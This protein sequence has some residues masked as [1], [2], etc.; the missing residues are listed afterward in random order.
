MHEMNARF[1]RQVSEEYKPYFH[2]RDLDV[3]EVGSCNVNGAVLDN[4][5]MPHIRTYIG[6]DWREG[7]GVTHIGLAHEMNFDKQFDVVIS[8]SM[9]EHDP[10]WRDSL[11]VMAHHLKETGLF[12][13]SWGA[14]LNL[15]HGEELAPDEEY[16]GLKVEPVL[17]HLRS[18][19]LYVHFFVYEGNHYQEGLN[20]PPECGMGEVGLVAFRTRKK[21]PKLDTLLPED[22]C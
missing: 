12:A 4:L 1:W 16:H 11:R 18:L 3:L 14:A 19:D 21:N 13:I 2:H 15:P 10:Y 22:R 7:P 9:L 6:V 20:V 5:D 17:R 8:A